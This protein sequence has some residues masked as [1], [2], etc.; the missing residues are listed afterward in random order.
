MKDTI[1]DLVG[2][3]IA[4]E[5]LDLVDLIVRGSKR[6]RVI[7]FFV[8]RERGIT[9]EDCARLSRKISDIL[10]FEGEALNLSSYRI[11]V[12]SPGVDRPLRTEKDF[13]RN[14]GKSVLIQ[15]RS[16]DERIRVEGMILGTGEET[17]IIKNA[18]GESE[19]RLNSIHDARIQIKWS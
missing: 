1:K 7:Q 19:I 15:Y 10:D 14:V 2:A 8:D 18:D 13:Q 5:G 12:S 17:V 11:E 4:D 16:N 3:T 9:V 6:S